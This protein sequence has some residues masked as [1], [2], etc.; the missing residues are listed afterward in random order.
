MSSAA[1]TEQL[2]ADLIWQITP[3]EPL[4]LKWLADGSVDPRRDEFADPRPGVLSD[5]GLVALFEGK[6]LILTE[7]GQKVAER[8][9]ID[10]GSS[11]LACIT[12]QH[13]SGECDRCGRLIAP[14]KS[15]C[16]RCSNPNYDHCQVCDVPITNGAQTCRRCKEV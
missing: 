11:V 1:A 12:V 7:L 14:G 4:F 8:C 3:G 16:V 13:P 10:N 2:A 5:Y 9:T 15:R 6:G